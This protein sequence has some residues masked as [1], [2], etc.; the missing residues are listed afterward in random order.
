MTV[1]HRERAVRARRG[2][3][4]S[5]I[6][7]RHELQEAVKE[8]DSHLT[9]AKA[10]SDRIERLL[11]GAALAGIPVAELA[12][13]TGW[14]RPTLYRMLE[15]SRKDHDLLGVARQLEEDLAQATEQFGSPA[16]L[17]QFAQ[18]LKIT[19]DELR[20]N[21]KLVFSTLV[22]EFEAMGPLAGSYMLNLLLE[23]PENEK[24]AIT[25]LLFQ[26]ATVEAVAESMQ[27]PASEVVVWISL[28]L[29]R[30]LPIMRARMAE[31]QATRESES[32]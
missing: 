22:G 10:A 8:R 20:A 3:E 21:L 11:S 15:R 25:P 27:Q 30:M 29:L 6:L 7:Y 1:L 12:R 18:G 23:I 28:G 2:Q 32:E 16:L 14:S 26:R 5:R 31:N 17:Y 4:A 9:Q 13:I 24:Y 19:P